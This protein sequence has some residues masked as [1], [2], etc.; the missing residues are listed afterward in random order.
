MHLT[1]NILMHQTRLLNGQLVGKTDH[2]AV[3]VDTTNDNRIKNSV[4]FGAHIA[5]VW[6]QATALRAWPMAA[7][8]VSRIQL[9]T[10]IWL[11]MSY[12]G[13]AER[14]FASVEYIMRDVM[15]HEQIPVSVLHV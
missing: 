15:C 10:G 14:A 3:G 4:T 1:D 2:A 9:V 5:Q 13:S 7:S 6:H 8:T 11:L 12:E